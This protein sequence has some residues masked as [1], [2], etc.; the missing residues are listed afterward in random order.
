MWLRI[1]L[2]AMLLGSLVMGYFGFQTGS[3][4]TTVVGMALMIF[5]GFLLYFLAKMSLMAGLVFVK[6]VV[7]IILV[8][9]LV[10]LGFRGCQILVDKGKKSAVELEER[11]RAITSTLKT[12][13]FFDNMKSYLTFNKSPSSVIPPS[14]TTTVIETQA[15]QLPQTRTGTVT[16]VLSGNVFQ[17]NNMFF[18]LYGIAAPVAGQKCFDKRSQSYN[19]GHSATQKLSKLVKGKKVTCQSVTQY[20]ANQIV[21]TCSLQGYDIGASMV[22]VGWALADR[23]VTL[24]YI[25]YEKE[26]RK[27]HL[28]LWAGKFVA[29]WAYE[30]PVHNTPKKGFLEGLFQ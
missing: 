29:P 23:R 10:L 3:A 20:A 27:A 5:L 22:S 17:M 16:K 1:T 9:A 26:A 11:S 15:T 19:C 8:G 25:P 30:A 21:A 18:K 7:I 12:P 14:S 13:S 4:T 6:V 28:G 24:A 2:W